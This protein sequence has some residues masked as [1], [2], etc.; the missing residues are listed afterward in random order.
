MEENVRGSMSASMPSEKMT[1]SLRSPLGTAASRSS[2]VRTA[3]IM[4]VSAESV[5]MAM[6]LAALSA[7]TGLPISA[8]RL[9]SRA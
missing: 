7:S 2:A 9:V 5:S 8:S 6:V 4:W 1:I 3:F